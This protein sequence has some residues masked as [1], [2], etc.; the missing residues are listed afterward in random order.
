MM[1]AALGSRVYYGDKGMERGWH[2]IKVNPEG[3]KTPL[4]HLDGAETAVTHWHNDTFDMPKDATLLASSAAYEHQ[5]FSYGRNCL[6]LQFHPEVTPSII[7]SWSVSSA[8]CVADGT[9]DLVKLRGDTD[10]YGEKLMGQSEKFMIEW[11]AALQQNRKA[12]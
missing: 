8:R 3:M 2:P 10:I 11:I 4:R 12:A 1:A 7:K 9:L 5:A 6:G